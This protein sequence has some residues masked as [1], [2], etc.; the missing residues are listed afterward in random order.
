MKDEI[1]DVSFVEAE[2]DDIEGYN[3]K[4][5]ICDKIIGSEDIIAENVP[6]RIK[7]I[8]GFAHRR[9]RARFDM[10]IVGNSTF[11]SSFSKG[12]IMRM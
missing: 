5:S 9:C 4:C 2:V 10:N 1:K 8:P 3:S 11:D 7:N 6:V 12:Q